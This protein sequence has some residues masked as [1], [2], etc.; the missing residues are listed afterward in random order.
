MTNGRDCSSAF[1]IRNVCLPSE[2]PSSDII[3]GTIYVYVLV[4]RGLKLAMTQ[5]EPFRPPTCLGIVSEWQI[6]IAYP[7]YNRAITYT[8]AA[9]Q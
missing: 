2:Y 6:P 5:I 7:S 1:V 9:P 4:W 8:I 3:R